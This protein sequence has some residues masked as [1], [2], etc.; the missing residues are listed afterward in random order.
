VP[1]IDDALDLAERHVKESRRLIA[2]QVEHSDRLLAISADTA[3]AQR[4]LQTFVA[5][6]K[7]FEQH[8]DRLKAAKFGRPGGSSAQNGKAPT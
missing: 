1:S 4:L 6:L 3:D 2:E 8:W 7:M 5:T